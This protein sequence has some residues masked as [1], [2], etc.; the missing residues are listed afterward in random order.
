MDSTLYKE[1]PI[2]PVRHLHWSRAVGRVARHVVLT[3]GAIVM[4]IPFVWMLLTTVKTLGESVRVPPVVVPALP[5]QWHNYVTAFKVSPFLNFYA[6]TILMT[7]G[8]TL[9]QLVFCSLAAYALA[10]I[11]FRGRTVL[12][13]GI[14]AL[15][16]VPHQ[17]PL[18]PQYLLMQ[19][20]GWL[21]TPFA[22]IIPGMFSVFGTFLLRQFFMT[23]P[24]ELEESAT[25]DG[26]NHIQIFWHV[27][28]PLVKPGL[29]ALAIFTV[30]W[31]WNDLLWPLIVI[32]SPQRTTLSAGLAS[33]EGQYFTN[34]PVLMAGATLAVWPMIL[35]FFVLQRHFVEGIALT[36]MKS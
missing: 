16:M 23:I 13:L 25:L 3:A 19:R 34:Y 4:V 20:F 30:L 33:L 35:L 15:L 6:N 27:L 22:L 32:N 21:N 31:S 5:L 29:I 8:R 36:G 12:F 17:L 28:L 1:R 7:V 9:G 24:Q 2:A 18:V 26:A 14:L 11:R 10:R